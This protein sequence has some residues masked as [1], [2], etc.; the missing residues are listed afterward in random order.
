MTSGRPTATRL[1]NLP[2][3]KI[4]GSSIS[5]RFVAA[6]T[7]I[8]SLT[9]KPSIS[10]SIW[11]RVCSRSSWPPP[12]P[13]PRLRATASISSINTIQGAFFFASANISLTLDAPT[14]TNISTKSEPDRLKNGTP[15]SPATAFARRV[16][17][18]PGGPTSIIPFGILAPTSVY[19]AGSA[20][21]S[22]ISSNSSFSSLRPAT[23]LN[24]FAFLSFGSILCARL[25]PKF[26]IFALL[27]LAPAD[28]ADKNENRKKIAIRPSP[29]GRSVVI[30][31][32]VFCISCIL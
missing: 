22:T 30:I 27:P 20:R 1:S 21:K 10:T 4:A 24:F 5:T 2:G 8:P 31:H 16:L 13:E 9:P 29:Y 25:F 19:L 3:L 7:I 17:P 6:I 15:A 11:L 23:S 26:I 14:P 32:D 28:C 18:V 12:S